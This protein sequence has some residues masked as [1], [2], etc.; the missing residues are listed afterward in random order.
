MDNTSRTYYFT[1]IPGSTFSLGIVLP[2][3]ASHFIDIENSPPVD[4]DEGG[5]DASFTALNVLIV[6]FSKTNRFQKLTI[7]TIRNKQLCEISLL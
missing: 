2:A 3:Y 4:I 5:F 1:E 7:M 6:S